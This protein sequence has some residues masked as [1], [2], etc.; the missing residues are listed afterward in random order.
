MRGRSSLE[1][2]HMP[3]SFKKKKK[4]RF[5]TPKTL[6]WH[7]MK[8]WLINRDPYNGLLLSLYNWVVVRPFYTANNHG[9]GYCSYSFGVFLEETQ[10]IFAFWGVDLQKQRSLGLH[11]KEEFTQT[12]MKQLQAVYQGISR[13]WCVSKYQV[14][15]K[16][17]IGYIQD[18]HSNNPNDTQHKL[19]MA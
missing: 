4:H 13:S 10:E 1:N 11:L 18:V 15:Y 3:R 5:V 16:K 19:W 17:K 14:V 8:Y 6:T 9:F 2:L 12:P 7:S